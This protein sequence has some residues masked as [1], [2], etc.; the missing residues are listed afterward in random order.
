[1]LN[2][3]EYEVRWLG[4]RSS[5]PVLLNESARMLPIKP[6][7]LWAPALAVACCKVCSTAIA[8]LTT[9]PIGWP[10]TCVEMFLPLI[11]V[12]SEEHTSEL[13]SLTNLVC[14]LLLEKKKKI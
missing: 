7:L 12:R 2:C 11:V 1:M 13:Q 4:A 8:S 6:E 10:Q 5:V 3:M 9:L 14:R